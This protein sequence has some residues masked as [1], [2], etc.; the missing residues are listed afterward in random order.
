MTEE[1][2]HIQEVLSNL[3][4]SDRK[5]TYIFEGDFDSE[6][7]VNLINFLNANTQPVNLFINSPGGFIN[8]VYPLMT[9]IEDY[10]DI[11]IYPLEQCSSSAF[12]LLLNTTVPI[13]FLDKTI[14]SVLH[15]PRIE[16][17]RD[18]NNNNIY[19]KDF[20]KKRRHLV[21]FNEQLKTLPLPTIQQNKLL[22]GEDV[23]LFYEDLIRIFKDRLDE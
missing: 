9:V 20:F 8:Y 15:F 19:P 10:E 22:K 3:E 2:A 16:S 13:K 12:F 5:I 1:E 14:V 17:W 23:Q 11:V 18:F 21:E 7:T 6:N 4:I